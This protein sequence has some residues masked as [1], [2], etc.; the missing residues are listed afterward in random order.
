MTKVKK[1]RKANIPPSE[2]IWTKVEDATANS[3]LAR[4]STGK[5]YARES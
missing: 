2:S 1:P 3:A 4:S 5:R